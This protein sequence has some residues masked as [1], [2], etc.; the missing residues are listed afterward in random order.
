MPDKVVPCSVVASAGGKSSSQLRSTLCLPTEQCAYPSDHACSGL[1][2][3]RPSADE[4]DI[5][6]KNALPAEE[7]QYFIC[8][9][10]SMP[11]YDQ[12][13]RDVHL[14]GTLSIELAPSCSMPRHVPPS[15]L[16]RS[17]CMGLLWHTV[18]LRSTAAPL[19]PSFFSAATLLCRSAVAPLS[20][21]IGLLCITSASASMQLSSR[22]LFAIRFLFLRSRRHN[23]LA[24]S[25]N[26][27]KPAQETQTQESLDALAA[28]FL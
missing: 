9:V 22:F 8:Y 26:N 21:N 20:G 25:S 27:A 2:W 13:V 6:R 23:I 24:P 15:A 12:Q 14:R 5:A 19:P 16:S 4:P 1:L 3:R 10:L 11:V 28:S 18:E 7:Q 17:V